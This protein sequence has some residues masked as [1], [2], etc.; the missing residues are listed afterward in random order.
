MTGFPVQKDA[1]RHWSHGPSVAVMPVRIAV[2]A[3]TCNTALGARECSGVT[4]S[5]SQTATSCTAICKETHMLA[6]NT[7]AAAAAAGP[8]SVL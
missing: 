4:V 3:W 7:A 2:D 8:V 5:R 1:R 6:V